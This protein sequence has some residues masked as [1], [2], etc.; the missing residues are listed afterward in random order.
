MYI[1]N[2]T[3]DYNN[4]TPTNC[5]DNEFFIDIILPTLFFTIPCCLSFLCLLSLMVYTLIKS[6]INKC[7]RNNYIQIIDLGVLKQDLPIVVNQY[8]L[9]I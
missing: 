8:F 7:F 1:A 9:Q 4:L 5:L 2:V 3:D 6:L